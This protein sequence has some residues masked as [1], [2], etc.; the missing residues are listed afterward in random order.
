MLEFAPGLIIPPDSLPYPAFQRP[1][2][3]SR[4]SRQTNALRL[5]PVLVPLE[6]RTVPAVTA[7]FAAGVLTV[8]STAGTGDDIISV[9]LVSGSVKV[10][11]GNAHA[12]VAI[13]GGP[14]ASKA[15][16]QIKANG[17]DGND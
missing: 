13:G 12:E 15:V 14:V 11:Q 2:R 6:T 4:V 16:T 3:R 8:D 9:E 7:N 10:F 5:R 17:N 1:V